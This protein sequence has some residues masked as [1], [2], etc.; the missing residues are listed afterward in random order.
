MTTNLVSILS[1]LFT[2]PAIP[3]AITVLI[4]SFDRVTATPQSKSQSTATGTLTRKTYPR[5]EIPQYQKDFVHS[6]AAPLEL[7]Q[8]ELRVF[9][10]GEKSGDSLEEDEK[11]E[12]GNRGHGSQFHAV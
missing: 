8:V 5:I 4:R 2:I 3:I 1:Y 12:G 6:H 11:F 7:N 10:G 9:G